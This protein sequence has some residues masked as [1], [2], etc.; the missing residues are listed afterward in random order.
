MPRAVNLGE[1]EVRCALPSKKRQ[2]V[3]PFIFFD[4]MA[5]AEFLTDTGLD[6]CPH[7]HIKLATLT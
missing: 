5:P 4:Q 3:G 7:P 1:M 2:M 6:V